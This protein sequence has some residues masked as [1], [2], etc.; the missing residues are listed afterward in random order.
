MR[1]TQEGC[2]KRNVKSLP[3]PCGAI[4][5]GVGSQRLST[6]RES[7]SLFEVRYS[8]SEGATYAPDIPNAGDV[9]AAL[10]ARWFATRFGG[11]ET[12]TALVKKDR[13]TA[14]RRLHFQPRRHRLKN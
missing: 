3:R 14:E 10:C 12:F 4:K 11:G 2:F 13:I 1:E 6:K 7:P 5:R 9:H 8:P